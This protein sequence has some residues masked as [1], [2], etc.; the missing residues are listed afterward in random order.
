[1]I[2]K[3]Q[4]IIDK[5]LLREIKEERRNSLISRFLRSKIHV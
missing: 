4:V 5:D 1:M 2:V 3:D